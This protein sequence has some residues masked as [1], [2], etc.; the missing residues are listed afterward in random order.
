[1]LF[2]SLM[3]K[4]WYKYLAGMS[5]EDWSALPVDSMPFVDSRVFSVV[6]P[7]RIRVSHV[8]QMLRIAERI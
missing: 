4:V 5:V 8:N 6:E 1:M 3:F 2:F 7:T